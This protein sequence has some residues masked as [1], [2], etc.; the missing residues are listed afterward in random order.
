MALFSIAN[1][2]IQDT[3][4][5]VGRITK[6]GNANILTTNTIQLSAEAYDKE[7]GIKT[8]SF[9]ASYTDPNRGPNINER[10]GDDSIP[11]Y[12]HLWDCSHLPDQ[13]YRDIRLFCKIV[14]SAGNHCTTDEIYPVLDRHVE[15]SKNKAIS[16]QTKNKI[17]VDGLF[18]KTWAAFPYVEFKNDDNDC[19]GFSCWDKDF[20]YFFFQIKDDF[21]FNRV[22]EVAKG[23]NAWDSMP[24]ASYAA[25][26]PP[27]VN[28]DDCLVL[29]FDANGSFSE[30]PE[31]DD[32]FLYIAPT[33]VFKAVSFDYFKRQIV[34][35]WHHYIKCRTTIQLSGYTVEIGIP[36]SVL[37]VM[38][39]NNHTLGFNIKMV[40]RENAHSQRIISSWTTLP[41]ITNNPSEWGK[42]VLADKPWGFLSILFISILIIL[43]ITLIYVILS[44]FNNTK[45]QKTL[46]ASKYGKAIKMAQDYVLIHY[47]NDELRIEDIAKEVGLNPQYFG[48]IFKKEMKISFSEYLNN[49]RMVNARE[50]LLKTNKNITEIA[51]EVGYFSLQNFQHVFKKSE[52]ISP[53]DFRKRGNP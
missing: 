23:E 25:G 24:I 8:V 13:S 17:N 10:I 39:R 6:P 4:P 52:K 42:L 53:G 5:P 48:R 33:G 41:N 19:K 45:K 11:P 49:V 3:L 38:P 7:S 16:H 22:H 30:L 9:F 36:W 46:P 47:R 15:L 18:E 28:I 35:N 34:Y 1:S 20:L 50:L 21:I 29:Y 31:P 40:D 43:T 32:K 44:V 51:Y 26:T 2:R 37:G 27:L 12:T 14:D